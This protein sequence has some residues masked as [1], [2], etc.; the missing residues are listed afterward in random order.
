MQDVQTYKGEAAVRFGFEISATC[1]RPKA[2]EWGTGRSGGPQGA[3]ITLM[4]ITDDIPA[5][6]PV[7]QW[8]RD[9]R[10]QR[11]APAPG[12]DI[13]AATLEWS[14]HSLTAD[15]GLTQNLLLLSVGLLGADGDP[16]PPPPHPI[17]VAIC[18]CCCYPMLTRLLTDT[19][20]HLAI[21]TDALPG[22][23]G[24]HEAV[25][26][27]GLIAMDLPPECLVG[28]GQMITATMLGRPIPDGPATA[29]DMAGLMILRGIGGE[30]PEASDDDGP[31]S[32][33]GRN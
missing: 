20:G 28:I 7:W 14:A 6:R 9:R 22:I 4:R 5:M 32:R 13:G 31:L 2:G 11:Y 18:I 3:P 16:S 10:A 17:R 29:E 30:M 33:L 8:L 25:P 27:A 23:T 1:A 26:M 24:P 15:T 12:A 21:T 19:A